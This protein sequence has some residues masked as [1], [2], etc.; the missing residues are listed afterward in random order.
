[1][2]EIQNNTSP[3][4]NIPN[5]RYFTIGEASKICDVK[6]H[7]LRYWESEFKD[8]ANGITLFF[9]ASAGYVNAN[10]APAWEIF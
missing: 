10:S 7:V 3:S 4:I 8:L 6:A 5:K 2:T 1:M 9:N